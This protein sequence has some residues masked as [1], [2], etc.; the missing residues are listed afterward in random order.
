[1]VFEAADADRP[2]LARS[3]MAA[4][5]D[6]PVAT[7]TTPREGLRPRV[8]RRF[9]AAMLGAKLPEGFVY[10]DPD[11]VGAALWAPPGHWRTTTMQDLRIAGAFA[12]PRLWPRGPRVARGLLGLERLHPPDPQHFYLS[13][14][15]VAPRAQGQG[16][17][18]RLLK[19]VLDICDADAVPAYLE[20]SKESNIA[21]YAR[22]GFRVTR[23]IKLPRG[24][25]VYAMWRE[26]LN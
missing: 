8:L 4:F 20:S 18:S 24:P 21:F 25:T 16:L 23:E 17:G 2:P 12:D 22:H 7:W 13:V 6:D 11:R 3:L 15:G 9:F 26:P 19:P 10:T 1:M 5:M 14:L